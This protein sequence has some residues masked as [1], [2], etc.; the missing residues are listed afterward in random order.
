[1][2]EDG[3]IVVEGDDASKPLRFH[4]REDVP[5]SS[6]ILRIKSRRWSQQEE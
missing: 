1:L 5:A 2:I 3:F 4:W 6:R